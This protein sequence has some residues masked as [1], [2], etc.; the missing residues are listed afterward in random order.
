MQGVRPARPDDVPAIVEL[1]AAAFEPYRRIGVAALRRRFQDPSLEM[2]VID[3]PGGLAGLLTVERTGKSL[4]ARELAAH[5]AARGQGV[6][7]KLMAKLHDAAATAGRIVVDA[8]ELDPR[9]VA[10]YES[11]GF[12]RQERL[13]DFFHAGCSAIRL[14]KDL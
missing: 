2:W 4:H 14:A 11:Q 12:V 1:Q 6:G 7:G 9:L 8:E 5:P 10:W 13:P 3:R